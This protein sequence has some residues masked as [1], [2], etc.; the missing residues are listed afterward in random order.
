MI[1]LFKSF[2]PKL[3]ALEKIEEVLQSGYMAEGP[4]VKEF[5]EKLAAFYGIDEIMCTNSCTSAIIIALRCIGIREG[6][7]IIT[8]PLTCIATNIPIMQLGGRIRWADVNKNNGMINSES[9]KKLI[10]QRTKAILILH[11]EGDFCEH[12]EIREIAIEKKIPIIEDCAHVWRTE[13]NGRRIPKDSDFACFSFQAIKHINT[14]DGG[15]L[16]CKPKYR[17]L[18]KK[19]KWFGIDRSKRNPNVWLE[20]IEI[21]GYKMNMNDMTA[22]L[23]IAQLEIIE[24]LLEKTYL[25][26][27]KYDSIFKKC[28][29][30]LITSNDRDI[31]R[32]SYWAYPIKVNNREEL[33]KELSLHDIEAKQI[34]PRNDTLK[35]F[36]KYREG[37]LKN[38]EEF[39]SKDLSLPCG[40]WVNEEE[41]DRISSL[42]IKYSK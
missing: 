26:G 18:A 32:S 37:Y 23:G 21:D 14:G 24:P 3:E 13:N 8:T 4:K 17:G 9:V 1:K 2:A 16:Y 27:K 29:N 36:S 41:I 12:K 7:E 35:V 30:E 22:A 33:I 19:F 34:H 25:N 5:E 15:A 42:V 10:N 11:K 40:W 20:D 28:K 31:N 6:D 38:L 39:D